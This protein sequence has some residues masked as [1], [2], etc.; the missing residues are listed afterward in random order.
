MYACARVSEESCVLYVGVCVQ[1]SRQTDEGAALEKHTHT[2][3]WLC[4]SKAR[5]GI[6]IHICVM[7]Y[8]TRASLVNFIVCTCLGA[9]FDTC[10]IKM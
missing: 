4:C 5:T 1:V 2:V 7:I 9:G 3:P 10:V 8:Y 6:R